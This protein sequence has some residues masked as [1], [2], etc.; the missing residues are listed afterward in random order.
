MTALSG[1]RTTA[2]MRLL[3]Q[4]IP[5]LHN[6]NSSLMQLS[7]HDLAPRNSSSFSSFIG[8]R[9]LSS[10]ASHFSPP[11]T[12]TTSNISS[13]SPQAIPIPASPPT[14][15]IWQRLGPLTWAIQGFGRS[16]R[17]RPYLTQFISTL[18]IYFLGDMSAQAIRMS[19]ERSKLEIA[20]SEGR[21]PEVKGNYE[22]ERTAKALVIGAGSSIPTYLWYAF[23]FR[24][25]ESQAE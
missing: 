24:A 10:S 14:I 16:Q 11:T 9:N 13:A 3:R 17:K 6:R 7:V 12:T 4:H 23:L 2:P 18:V 8:K 1:L 20:R 25:G 19:D 15:P 21:D 22:P 5:R